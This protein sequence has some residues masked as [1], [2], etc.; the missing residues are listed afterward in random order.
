MQNMKT[1][2]DALGGTRHIKTT[3][4]TLAL[5]AAI[6]LAAAQRS[7]C[8]ADP[9]Y[10]FKVVTTIGSPAPG[11]GAFASDFEPTGLNNRG[12]LAFTAE[13]DELGEEGIFLAGGSG[14]QQI[15]RFGQSAPGGGTF[16]AAELGMIGL[17]DSGDAAFAFS[18]VPPGGTVGDVDFG[19]PIYGGLYRWSHRTAMLSP[20]VVPNVTPDPKGGVFAGSAF[21]ASLNNLG[22]VAFTGFVTNTPVGL[23]EGVFIQRPSG[24]ISTIVRTG[25]PSPDGGTFLLSN[26]VLNVSMNDAGDVAFSGDTTVDADTEH[27]KV[28][29]RRAA[30]GKIELIPQPAGVVQQG[31]LVVNNRGDIVFGG[32]YI[33]PSVA[34]GQGGVYLRNGDKTSI[35]AQVGAPAPGG[36]TFNFITGVSV[37]EEIALNNVGDVAFGAATTLA[38]GSVDEAVYYYSGATKKLRRLAGV[39]TVIP[40]YGTIVSLEQ[41]GAVIVFPPPPV[42]GFPLSG[43]TLND[44]GQVGFV[45]TLTDGVTVFGALLMGT[46]QSFNPVPKGRPTE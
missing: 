14:I 29:F 43:M 46:P 4:I 31:C 39:G 19:P 6:G 44:L 17:N 16:S 13:P 36:G 5:L 15:V 45:A 23:G 32:S 12:Q 30:S 25:D 40:G 33:V 2:R 3:P 37:E 11:G 18:L 34:Y 35:I 20:V 8:A 26:P 24:S 27:T 42:E 41:V 1:S 7:A 28:Y 21:D 10:T 38:D 9:P 22:T